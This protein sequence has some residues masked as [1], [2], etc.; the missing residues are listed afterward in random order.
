MTWRENKRAFKNMSIEWSKCF[1]LL[2][3]PI[4]HA[5]C[6]VGTFEERLRPCVCNEAA[7]RW[8]GRKNTSV[9]H[10]SSDIRPWLC[11]SILSNQRIHFVLD[12][13]EKVDQ[14]WAMKCAQRDSWENLWWA[15][16]QIAVSGHSTQQRKDVWWSHYKKANVI[17]SKT[18]LWG[19]VGV[20]AS[21]M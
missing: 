9:H 18:S 8:Q 5:G 6:T 20:G 17:S 1:D 14:L 4:E 12:N 15:G 16:I 21:G 13:A 7:S 2:S 3:V 19:G 11:I 10:V